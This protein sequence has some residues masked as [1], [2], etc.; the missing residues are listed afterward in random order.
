GAAEGDLKDAPL[1]VQWP[2]AGWQIQP[3]VV[4]NMPDYH[5][6]ARGVV[7]WQNLAVPAPFKEDTWVTSIQVIPG[8][9]AVVHHM[10]F[11][12]EVHK[13][14]TMYNTYEWVEVPRDGEGLPTNRRVGGTGAAGEGGTGATGEGGGGTV[15]RDGTVV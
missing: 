11:G 6:P 1:P 12:F 14:T 7:D 13:P 15:P 3:D 5:V 10:C 4:V 8:D 2:A 9:A